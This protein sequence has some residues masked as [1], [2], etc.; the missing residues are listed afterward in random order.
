M[1]AAHL[2][3]CVISPSCTTR[4]VKNIDCFQTGFLKTPEDFQSKNN[5]IIVTVYF[6]AW[7]QILN[8]Y[9]NFITV[10]LE[11]ICLCFSHH[12]VWKTIS[13]KWNA[14]NGISDSLFFLVACRTQTEWCC[15]S[16]ID[17]FIELLWFA[18][19]QSHMS[20]RLWLS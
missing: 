5:F 14:W 17:W 19:G 3:L 12:V 7:S 16:G 15:A 20:D 9:F 18:I 2:M 13:L 11:F 1:N 6:V 8:C 4:N 10:I